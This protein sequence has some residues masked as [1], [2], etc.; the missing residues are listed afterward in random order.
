MF[1]RMNE[2]KISSKVIGHQIMK[3]AKIAILNGEFAL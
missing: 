2:I 1:F 3:I